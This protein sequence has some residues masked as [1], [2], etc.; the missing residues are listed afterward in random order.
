MPILPVFSIPIA[1]LLILYAIFILFFLLYSFFNMYHVLRFG[2]AN[3]TTCAIV[4]VYVTGS[5]ILLGVSAA[6]LL[7]YDWSTPFSVTAIFE[8]PEGAKSLFDL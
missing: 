1:V 7:R 3:V 4:A 5:V 8:G 6:S 2:V